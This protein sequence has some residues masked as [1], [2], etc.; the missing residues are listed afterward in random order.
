[1]IS[2]DALAA[3]EAKIADQSGT[4]PTFHVYDAGHA[5]F[6]DENL[7]GTYDAEQ[8]RLAWSRTLQ[9]LRTHVR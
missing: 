4:S 9:T 8:A 2:T 3:L 6:N 1:M 7:L 5:F